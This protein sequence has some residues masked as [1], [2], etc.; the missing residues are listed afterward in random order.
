M[1][2]SWKIYNSYLTYKLHV[3]IV[4]SVGEYKVNNEHFRNCISHT[5]YL[6]LLFCIM[7]VHH[8]SVHSVAG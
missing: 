3:R 1:E 4:L 2:V 5:Y 6:E 8:S 7:S